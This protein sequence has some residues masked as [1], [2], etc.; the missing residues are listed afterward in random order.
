MLYITPK[1]A[2]TLSVSV[3]VSVSIN[4]CVCVCVCADVYVTL[5]PP[6]P[7]LYHTTGGPELTP[8]RE[9]MAWIAGLQTTPEHMPSTACAF[10]T[11]NPS[12]NTRTITFPSMFAPKCGSRY[13]AAHSPPLDEGTTTFVVH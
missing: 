1:V 11:C 2:V 7:M 12:Q 13:I 8:H 6:R 5:G 9:A 3:S 10:W 4:M